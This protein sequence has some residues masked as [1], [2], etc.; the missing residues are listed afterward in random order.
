MIRACRTVPLALSLVL[1]TPLGLLSGTPAVAEI[2]NVVVE[3]HVET[4]N[5]ERG[6]YAGAEAGDPVAISIAID[7]DDDIGV[8]DFHRY[9]TIGWTVTIDG[10]QMTSAI[11]PT[12]GFTT[13][14]TFHGFDFTS[15]GL[16]EPGG[17]V[18]H[19]YL[20]PV[21]GA[22]GP[23]DFWLPQ[24]SDPT[25]HRGVWSVDLFDTFNDN[26]ITDINDELAI[27][28][29]SITIGV[30]LDVTGD[31]PGET[32]FTVSGATPLG[33]VAVPASLQDGTFQVPGG[34]CEGLMIDLG[35]PLL[36]NAPFPMPT[37]TQGRA[38]RTG[39]VN[40]DQCGT[41]R[42]QAV[43]PASCSKSLEVLIE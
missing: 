30:Q 40:A 2:L 19:D 9:E 29:D 32:T 36:P 21:F 12:F 4:N 10:V 27:A 43:D 39:T 18:D 7:T 25:E 15:G 14:V 5:L 42:A 13:F 11:E 17:G 23:P 3:G 20:L 8:G 28:M 6:P 24:G 38:T 37:D 41:L 33:T 22:S 26:R 1:L 31:C 34:V 35:M 16:L